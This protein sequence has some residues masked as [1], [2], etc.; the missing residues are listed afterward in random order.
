MKAEDVE[1]IMKEMEVAKDVAEVAL[2]QSQGN[3]VVAL[4]KLVVE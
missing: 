4:R 3:V 1:F 2:K